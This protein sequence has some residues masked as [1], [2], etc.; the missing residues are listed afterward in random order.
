[1]YR[2]ALIALLLSIP[3]FA[4]AADQTLLGNTLTVKSNAVAT[5]R[6]I[7]VK[8]KEV[9]SPNTIVGD[10]TATGATLEVSIDGADYDGADYDGVPR[11]S[12]SPCQ[13]APRYRGSRFG[14]VMRS[15]GTNTRT[16]SS[17]RARSRPR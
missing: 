15:R 4:R 16:R 6:K 9:A 12:S 11:A 8:A 10:P 5:K 13:S 3:M 14:A 1:M 7:L 2:L 17:R